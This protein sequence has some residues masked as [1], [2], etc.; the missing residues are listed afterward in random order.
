M[1]FAIAI[2]PTIKM[3][4]KSRAILADATN[5]FKNGLRRMTSPQSERPLAKGKENYPSQS[6]NVSSPSPTQP[7]DALVD[8]H[9][10]DPVDGMIIIKTSVPST[11]DI[12]RFKVPENISFRAFRAKVELKVGFAVA[13]TDGDMSGRQVVSDDGFKRWVAGRVKKGRN[14]PI[15]VH[16]KQHPFVLNPSTP[17]S[18]L[19]PTFPSTPTTPVTPMTPSWP[20][21]PTAAYV[22]TS[23]RS[24]WSP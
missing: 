23:L 4:S 8:L 2:S 20:V 24:R 1:L 17:T 12:W 21:T 10:W 11:G 15:T 14:R 18:P 7:S 6:R 19:S 5:G 9:R 13:F 22:P 16:K 3:S